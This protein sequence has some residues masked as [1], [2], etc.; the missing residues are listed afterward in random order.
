[1]TRCRWWWCWSW[2]ALCGAVMAEP[3]APVP[4]PV[5][6]PAPD[7]EAVAP[8]NLNERPNVFGRSSSLILGAAQSPGP[9]AKTDGWS[10]LA[11]VEVPADTIPGAAPQRPHHALRFGLDAPRLWLRGLGVDSTDCIGQLR[12]PSKLRSDSRTGT[13][14]FD[15]QLKVGMQCRF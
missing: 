15:A 5:S 14:S 8:L 3:P 11:I 4:V 6:M 10:T 12:A 13:I 1:M 2:L 7:T 9:A